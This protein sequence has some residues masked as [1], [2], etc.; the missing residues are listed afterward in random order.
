MRAS[1]LATLRHGDVL[2]GTEGPQGFGPAA[3]VPDGVGQISIRVELQAT[4][5]TVFDNASVELEVLRQ[6]EA[7]PLTSA[8][9]A[10]ADTTSP[11][12]RIANAALAFGRLPAGDYV[13]RCTLQRGGESSERVARLISKR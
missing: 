1:P 2:I 3:R 9:M 7:K 6:G 12:K 8:T 10:M 4:D 5:A 13:L 11:L